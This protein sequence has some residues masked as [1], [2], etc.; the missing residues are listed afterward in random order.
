MNKT[1]K[2]ISLFFCII[3]FIL[4]STNVFSQYTEYKKKIVFDEILFKEARFYVNNGDT[5]RV[6]GILKNNAKIHGIPCMKNIIYEPDGKMLVFILSESFEIKGCIM[7]RGT[8][9]SYGKE[10]TTLLFG[11][12]T[13][14]QGYCCKGNFEKWYSTGI[15]T[16]LY[17]DGNLNGF[18][19]CNNVEIDEIPCKASPFANVHLH[20]SG[21]LKDC[22]LSKKH[23]IEETEYKK[24]THLSFDKSGKLTRANKYVFWWFKS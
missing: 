23:I 2:L 16:T 8:R 1:R 21:K 7:P 10:R 24:N 6:Q 5:I 13:E 9:V 22:T 12:D 14:Y 3:V 18:Y 15:F 20:P 19:P 4:I 17:L 11:R